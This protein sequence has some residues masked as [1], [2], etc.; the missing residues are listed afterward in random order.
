MEYFSNDHEEG[1]IQE[2]SL[3]H[4]NGLIGKT[5][6]HPSHIKVVQA[7]HI[8]TMEDYLDARSILQNA[9]TY[10]GV[11]KSSFLTK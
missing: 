4:A 6:I 11:L 10:N 9:D 8:V 3:D 5:V 2:V 1:L 7:M